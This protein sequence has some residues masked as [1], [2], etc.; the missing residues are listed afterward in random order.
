MPSRPHPRSAP[1]PPLLRA[2]V[3]GDWLRLDAPLV[4]ITPT[5]RGHKLF[6]RHGTLPVEWAG[7]QLW[8]DIVI[9]S[10]TP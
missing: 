10:L 9:V 3:H 8:M 1:A 6:Q 5:R 4:I 7:R 2:E